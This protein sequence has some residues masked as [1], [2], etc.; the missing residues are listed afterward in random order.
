[1]KALIL[2][3]GL[4]TRLK[5]L[6]ASRPKALMPVLNRPIISRTIEHLKSYGVDHIAV[7]A[8]HHYDQIVEYLGDGSAF[9]VKIEVRI[10]E[11]IL[12]TG[13]AIRNFSDF[14]GKEPFIVINADILTNIPLSS[15]CD[16]H[17][18][19][20]R[21][22]TMILHDYPQFNQILIDGS[23]QVIDISRQKSSGRLAFTGIHILNPEIISLIPGSGYSDI[24]DCYKTLTRKGDLGA[25]V[26]QD[27]YWRDIGSPESYVAAHEDLFALQADSFIIGPDSIVDPT[28][29]FKGWAAVGENA[30]LER[31]TEI[32]RSVLWD[33]VTVKEGVRISNS[34]IMSSKVIDR[35]VTD[36]IM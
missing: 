21:S 29:R 12:G 1:M 27:H 23:C 25:F 11:E 20:G 8:H 19:S 9:G 7:N 17:L 13:G 30:A 31:G 6:T 5:A 4:G 33:H 22:V 16:H 3:A 14:W 35:D 36:E 32:E 34:I 10:E 18:R 24:I 26:S 15:A 28:V 2:A